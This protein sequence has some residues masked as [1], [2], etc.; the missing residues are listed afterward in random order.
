MS[1]NPWSHGY[2]SS[3]EV[4]V[5]WSTRATGFPTRATEAIDRL[6][7]LAVYILKQDEMFVVATDC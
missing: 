6:L 1:V 7:H 2:R 4:Q 3:H 5:T